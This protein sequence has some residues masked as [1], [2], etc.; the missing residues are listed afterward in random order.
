MPDSIKKAI[1]GSGGAIILAATLLASGIFGGK[2][3]DTA[4]SSLS[5]AQAQ[6]LKADGTSLVIQ[7]LTWWPSCSNPTTVPS[8]SVDTLRNAKSV[9]LDIGGYILLDASSTGAEAVDRAYNSI[10]NDLWNQLDFAAIDFEIPQG[11]GTYCYSGGTRIS[12][13]TVCDALDELSR[14]GA[15]RLLYTSY[16]EWGSHLEPSN[17]L[18]CPNTYLW[19][20]SWNGDPNVDFDNHPFGGWQA[21]DVVLKQ[22]TGNVNKYGFYVDL[23]SMP[24]GGFPWLTPVPVVQYT[25]WG[26]CD[27]VHGDVWNIETKRWVFQGSLEY[28]P[29]TDTFASPPTC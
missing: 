3:V 4:G 11:D 26:A 19:L 16:G 13:Q 9:G 25:Q 1:V 27:S 15:P 21:S 29:L 7:A 8:S 2:A 17:P 28:D 10:P 22:Y 24:V 6:Q 20:A 14:L 5:L 23:D 18:G 12:E